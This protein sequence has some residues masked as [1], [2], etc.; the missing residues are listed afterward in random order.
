MFTLD[1]MLLISA[2]K[3]S[4]HLN[5]LSVLSEFLWCN[6]LWNLC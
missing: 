5:F 2:C 6:T 1:L 3:C 4:R